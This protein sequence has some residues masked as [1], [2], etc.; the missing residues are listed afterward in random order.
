MKKENKPAIKENQPAV[1]ENNPVMKKKG[2]VQKEYVPEKRKNILYVVSEAAPFIKTG[3]LADVAGSLPE[4][5]DTRFYDCRVIL[6]KYRCMKDIPASPLQ[7]IT[8]FTI[9]MVGREVYAGILMAKI[10][11]TIYYFIDNEE[12]FGGP[13]PYD[14]GFRD[15]EKFVFFEK[16]A[17]SALRLIDWKP[18]L[19]HC[20][21]WQAGL[22]PAFLR[23][24]AKGDRFYQGIKTVF[25][26]HNLKFQGIWNLE[27]VRRLTGLP[28]EYFT[29]DALEYF[30]NA[31]MLKGGIVY[32]DAVTTVS[33][34]YA[35]EIKTPEYGEGLDGLLAANANKLRGIVNGIDT[36]EYDPETDPRIETNYS[37]DSFRR[38]KNRNKLALQKEL[39]LEVN[40]GRFMMGMCTRLTEQKGLD[41]IACVMNEMISEDLQL[42]VI[43]T[44]EKK[45]EEMFR[46]AAQRYPGKV[47]AVIRFSER[48]ARQVY[49]GADAYLMPSRFEPCGLSQLIALRYGTLPVVRET[50]GLKDTVI[51]YNK[52]T[53][54]GT[55]FSFV[56][57]N[58][59]EMLDTI[60]FARDTF[61]NHKVR[62]NRLIDQ[63]MGTDYSWK[64]SALKYQELYDWLIGY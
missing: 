38:K 26:I 34:T 10:G 48:T 9:N 12:Y 5:L 61:V 24:Y 39:G 25:T 31:N 29:M 57:Y 13:V 54:E 43:G 23:E 15:I 19:I 27:D 59:H 46:Q 49:A 7:Y 37:I 64:K 32:S 60:R 11:D 52:Y 4:N 21:D 1:K 17:L 62:W 22:L 50:G 53:G 30:G 28:D 18:E 8:S 3:G 36:V 2:S 56:N 47:V 58:A 44:G 14:G 20:H 42:V 55:G 33:E 45:Y 40:S 35:E 51:P 63:A 16:A 6:P 41:L